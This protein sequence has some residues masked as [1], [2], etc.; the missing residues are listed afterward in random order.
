MIKHVYTY[1][2]HSIHILHTHTDILDLMIELFFHRVSVIIELKP[3]YLFL[4]IIIITDK[5]IN[6][7]FI[8]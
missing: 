8:L 3:F 5:L 4:L 2:L 6:L 7:C 1:K